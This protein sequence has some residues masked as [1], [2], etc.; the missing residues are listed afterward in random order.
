MKIVEKKEKSFFRKEQ[1]LKL[2]LK[3]IDV[4]IL[5]DKGIISKKSIPVKILG[6]GEVK[7]SIEISA[8][9][10]QEFIKVVATQLQN[11]CSKIC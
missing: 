8:M 6:N 11:L 9:E 2:N 1:A 7:K 5:Y 4:D 10:I 3:K